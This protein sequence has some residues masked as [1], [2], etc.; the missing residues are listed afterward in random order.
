MA[1]NSSNPFHLIAVV[2]AAAKTFNEEH[3]ADAE[4][5]TK[6][7]DNA[8]DFI[9]WA[10]GVGAGRVT[11]TGFS[12]DPNDTNLE[13]FKTQRHQTHISTTNTARTAV[14]NGLPPFPQGDQANL[15]VL[16]LLNT[17][18]SQQADQQEDQN[19]ILEKQVNPLIKKENSSKNCVKNF[20]ESTVKMILFASTM[21]NKEVPNDFT[22]S[23]K[24]FMNSKTVALAE[25]ELNQQFKTRGMDK[26]SFTTGYTANMYAGSF[27]WSSGDTPSNH[28]SFA[29][30]KVEP[31]MAAEHK[32]HHLTLQLVLTQ[33]RGLMLDKIKPSNKQEVSAPMNFNEMNKQV[34]MFTIVN[35]IFFSKLSVGS[36][37]LRA[38]LRMMENNKST[39]KAR[40]CTDEKFPTK[41]LFAVDSCFQ[42]WLKDCRK[43]AS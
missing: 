41:F 42:L 37:C 35:N 2:N 43:A 11:K 30:S 12:I 39:L 17:T 31:I 16:G 27:L 18:I 22:N 26:V 14:P 9:L 8:G 1:A 21:D 24:C 4:Y 6:V 10:W 15:A 19:K 13:L 32:N 7:T 28:S 29:F 40:E 20:H 5:I 36:Q 38:L 33:G 25:Q 23:C 3:N 34:K